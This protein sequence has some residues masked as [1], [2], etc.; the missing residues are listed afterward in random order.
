MAPPISTKG[1]YFKTCLK[2]PIDCLF[3]LPT[4]WFLTKM[5]HPDIYVKRDV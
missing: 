2:F 4:F 1:G 5:W 3:S